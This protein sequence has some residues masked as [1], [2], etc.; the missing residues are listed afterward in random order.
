MMTETQ[1]ALVLVTV[2]V[3]WILSDVIVYMVTKR[4]S[5]VQQVPSPPAALPNTLYEELANLRHLKAQLD[6]P[7]QSHQHIW[8]REPDTRKMGWLRYHCAFGNCP[9][10]EWRPK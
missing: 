6:N 9:A 4:R 8:P 5:Q 10:I 1:I 2:V 3:V 7:P